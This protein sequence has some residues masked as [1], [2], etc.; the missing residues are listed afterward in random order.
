M[1]KMLPEISHEQEEIVLAIDENNVVVNAV[2]GSGK[3][4]T[5]LFIAKKYKNKRILLLTYNSKLK[6]DTKKKA[7]S[8]NIKNLH[9]FNYHSFCCK[10]YYDKC[11]NDM[12]I[13]KIIHENINTCYQ[14]VNY[15]MMIIDETQDM[16]PL[17]YELVCKIYRDNDKPI[18]ICILGDKHQSIYAFNK[19]DSRF[20]SYADL[21][22]RM[23]IFNWKT[24]SLS[25]SYRL[26]IP[27]ANFMN[28]CLLNKN[29]LISTK[30]SKILPQYIITNTFKVKPIIDIIQSLLNEGTK[31][32]YDDIFILSPSVKNQKSPV[33]ILA[34]ELSMLNIPLYISISDD[35]YV[36]ENISKNKIII[37]SFHQVKGLER[38]VCF[39][40]NFD[41]SYFDYYKKNVQTSICPNEI[42][43]ACT[44]ASEALYLIHHN[45]NDYL[46]CLNVS[47]LSLFSEISIYDELTIKLNN[48]QINHTKILNVTE[49]INN[50]PQN[51][52]YESFKLIEI[53]CINIKS[54]MIDIP[55]FFEQPFGWENVSEITGTLL[56]GLF[57]LKMKNSISYLD[58]FEIEDFSKYST[59]N[60]LRITNEWLCNRN[61]LSYKTQQIINY[62]W[63]TDKHIDMSICRLD[64]LCISKDAIFEYYVYTKCDDN[65]YNYF[66]QGYIDCI[67]LHNK[68]IYEFKAVSSFT[69]NHFL[70]VV[71]YMFLLENTLKTQN[72]IDNSLANIAIGNVVKYYSVNSIQ[73]GHVRKVDGNNLLI[74]N[75]KHKLDEYKHISKVIENASYMKLLNSTDKMYVYISNIPLILNSNVQIKKHE[76]VLFIDDNHIIYRNCR[77]F[78]E[79]KKQ[80][81]KYSQYIYIHD[82]EYY[83]FNILTNEKL[84]IKCSNANIID[85]MKT[86]LYNKYVNTYNISDDEYLETMNVIKSSYF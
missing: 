77:F 8:Y 52:I 74:Q 44:R 69:I 1:Y 39:I 10:Y 25:E 55:R 20:I 48:K 41:N 12:I 60:L 7:H 27:I 38:K 63:L 19:A 58:E 40:Y 22:F 42:Y 21:I 72:D 11:I 35:E 54:C 83:I 76:Y 23:N 79:S 15:D 59:E 6:V 84:K 86:I 51:I 50:V 78:I 82:F 9:V 36:N 49:L 14:P 47:K 64:E 24:L 28:E 17:Y 45:C 65:L 31:Y 61:G 68:K 32:S 26:N 66:I 80:F 34:N 33:R 3:T 70:Q 56:P 62:N 46:N 73:Y 4:T 30:E 18:Q 13:M 37:S 67:D 71:I 16:T 2:A 43:V 85:M 5:C 57:E 29:K 75:E 81:I 53:T